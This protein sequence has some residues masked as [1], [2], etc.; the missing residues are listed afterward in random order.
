MNSV[1]RVVTDFNLCFWNLNGVKNKFML[2]L[3]N[4][5]IQSSDV[6][7]ITETHFN[8][9][10]KCPNN[11]ILVESSPPVESKRPRGGV[12][13]YKKIHC[14]LQFVTLLNLPDCIVCEVLNTGIILIAIYIPPSTSPFFKEDYFDNLKSMLCYFTQHRTI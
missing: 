13:I 4:S 7:I 11:F 14:S 5:V 9:R 8:K 6:L 10:T 2:D 12:A 1:F 3:T